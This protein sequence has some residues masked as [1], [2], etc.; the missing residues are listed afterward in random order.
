M[1]FEV[2]IPRKKLFLGINHEFFQFRCGI[3]SRVKVKILLVRVFLELC[4][5]FYI[6]FEKFSEKVFFRFQILEHLGIPMSEY[7]N[8][9]GIPVLIENENVLVLSRRSQYWNVKMV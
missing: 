1:K 9:C 2:K 6:H 4:G 3:V 8:I 7:C 5:C